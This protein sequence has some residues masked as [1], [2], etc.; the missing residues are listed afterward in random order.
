MQRWASL[1]GKKK[2]A[3]TSG[4]RPRITRFSGLSLRS[5]IGFL[6]TKRFCGYLYFAGMVSNFPDASS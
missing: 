6:P 5:A 3:Q 2:A 1:Q 4:G